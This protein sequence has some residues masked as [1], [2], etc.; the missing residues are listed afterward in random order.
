[1]YEA[2]FAVTITDPNIVPLSMLQ[3]LA[4]K[5]TEHGGI[6]ERNVPMVGIVKFSCWIEGDDLFGLGQEYEQLRSELESIAFGAIEMPER[7]DVFHAG[8]E[9]AAR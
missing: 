5:I 6:V 9:V 3:D 1:M 4:G 8:S 7:P 2:K